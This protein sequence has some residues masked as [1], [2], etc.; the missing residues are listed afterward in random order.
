[1]ESNRVFSLLFDKVLNKPGADPRVNGFEK[2]RNFGS[3]KFDVLRLEDLH[4]EKL[5]V[6]AIERTGELAELTSKA[7]F[8]SC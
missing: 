8:W 2:V 5:R 3:R 6:H 7:M 1:M 4:N